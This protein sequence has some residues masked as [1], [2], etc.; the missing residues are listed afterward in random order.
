MKI[1]TE[2]TTAWV[3]IIDSRKY[4]KDTMCILYYWELEIYSTGYVILNRNTAGCEIAFC[5]S[6]LHDEHSILSLV[7]SFSGLL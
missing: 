2:T 7:F 3:F 4:K 5:M 1:S 6:V